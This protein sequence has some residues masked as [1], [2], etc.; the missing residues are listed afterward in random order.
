M[1]TDFLIPSVLGQEIASPAAAA[2][3]YKK[4]REHPMAKASLE[5]ANWDLFAKAAGTAL[6]QM[7]GGVRDRIEVGMSIGIQ[8]SIEALAERVG[9]FVNEGYGRIL[10]VG[11]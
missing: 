8:L 3:R 2:N 1:L 4:V 6:S 11:S 9:K 10:D 7:I 5:N